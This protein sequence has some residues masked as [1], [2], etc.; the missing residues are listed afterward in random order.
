LADEALAS[1][2]A[3]VKIDPGYADAYNNIGAVYRDMGEKGRAMEYFKKALDAEPGHA[4]AREN[5]SGLTE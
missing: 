2:R 5:L 3:A 1:Y 4:K